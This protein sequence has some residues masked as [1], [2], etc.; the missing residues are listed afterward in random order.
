MVLAIT[1]GKTGRLEVG[2]S[3]PNTQTL[4]VQN[5]RVPLSWKTKK[6]MHLED[7]SETT[8]MLLK[9]WQVTGTLTEDQADSGQDIIRAAYGAGSNIAVKIWMDYAGAPTLF[10]TCAYGR[11]TRYE[12]SI[13]PNN[14]VKADF[15]IES[16]G[17][18]MTM[19]V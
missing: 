1:V 9:E 2:T 13:D 5:L 10:Y 18:A 8:I 4:G 14:E 19:P 6:V 11:V 16:A 17:T 7:T 15:T 3:T 12:T